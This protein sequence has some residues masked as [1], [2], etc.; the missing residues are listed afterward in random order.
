MFIIGGS[1]VYFWRWRAVSV[2][3]VGGVVHVVVI[4]YRTDTSAFSSEPRRL[5]D[6]M[7]A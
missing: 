3:V 2:V 5:L 1:D 7:K 4:G 6:R